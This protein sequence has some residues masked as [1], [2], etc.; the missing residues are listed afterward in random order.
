MKSYLFALAG[1]AIA[2]VVVAGCGSSPAGDA[3]T[4]GVSV[5]GTKYLLTSEPEGGMDVIQVRET[6]KD[7]DEVVIVGRI[8]GSGDPW[9]KGHAAFSIVDRSL[10]SCS[11][12]EG[13][14][15][16]TPWD[17]CCEPRESLAKAT[18]LVKVVDEDGKIIAAGASELLKVKELATVVVRGK[19]QRD[20]DGNLTVLATGVFV[21][22]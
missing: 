9:V 1:A 21:K 7:K 4:S 10:K 22:K 14:Q 6:A 13:D 5:D 2:C 12:I 8:G 15:C 3:A 20:A 11:D 19:A 16:P 17:Y 18:A